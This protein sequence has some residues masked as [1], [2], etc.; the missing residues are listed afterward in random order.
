[1]RYGR[2]VPKYSIH[3]TVETETGTRTPAEP[4]ITWSA[5]R[6]VAPVTDFGDHIHSR[7]TERDGVLGGVYTA[8][9]H[10]E[11]LG[12]TVTIDDL[13]VTVEHV[14]NVLKRGKVVNVNRRSSDHVSNYRGAFDEVMKRPRPLGS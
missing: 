4:V 6:I 8:I 12:E 2:R 11:S 3:V 7:A 14:T 10:A 13:A 5:R 1:M 9:K